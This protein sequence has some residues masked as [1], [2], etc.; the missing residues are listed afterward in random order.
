MKLLDSHLSS[1]E[2][3]EMMHGLILLAWKNAKD[4]DPNAEISQEDV[5]WLWGLWETAAIK[6]YKDY[7]EG[8]IAL[9]K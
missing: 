3:A 9:Q 6:H 5:L 7:A 4:D 8:I 2:Y 1:I